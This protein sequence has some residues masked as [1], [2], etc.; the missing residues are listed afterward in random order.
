MLTTSCSELQE[1]FRR[2]R[3]HGMS[4]ND[5]ERHNSK[6]VVFEAYP[7]VGYNYRMTDIQA[8]I[9]RVQLTRL[10]ELVARR[11]ELSARYHRKLASIEGVT[12][13]SEPPYARS[14][15]QSYCVRLPA[16]CD[17]RQVMQFMLDRG[18]ATRRGIMNA[19]REDAYGPRSVRHPLAESERAQEQA[20][21]LPLYPRMSDEDQSRVVETLAAAIHGTARV[22]RQCGA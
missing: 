4:I 11:R 14:N 15:W 13:P 22:S 21:I 10:T 9:G 5:R 19:H 20:I 17:Q 3:Q 2:M 6:K 8:A 18:V 1:N 7:A 12:A 16:H